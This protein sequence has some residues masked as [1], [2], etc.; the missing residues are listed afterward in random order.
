M[1]TARDIGD[2]CH[3]RHS[4]RHV[5]AGDRDLGGGVI[6]GSRRGRDNGNSDV[7]RLPGILAEG[8]REVLA[9]AQR[10]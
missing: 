7:N 10:C 2:A 8:N 3:L 6:G 9:V 4:K 5:N 1:P